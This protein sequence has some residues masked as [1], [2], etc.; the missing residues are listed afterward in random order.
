MGPRSCSLLHDRAVALA[1][2][3]AGH[4]MAGPDSLQQRHGLL[5]GQCTLRA[6]AVKAADMRR[7]ID[8]A[9]RLAGDAQARR[10]LALLVT[11]Q[12]EMR[13][14][15]Q[16]R[17]GIGMLRVAEDSSEERRVGKECVSTCR[18]RWSPYN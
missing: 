5:A 1:G 3:M 18:S 4:R 16:Q 10:G 15:R 2:E 12:I 14:R 13:D 17:P 9:A 7:R 6:A 11:A 8:R